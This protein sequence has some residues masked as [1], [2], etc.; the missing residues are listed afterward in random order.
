MRLLCHN[1]YVVMYFCKKLHI[2]V[3]TV[4]VHLQLP[5]S[6]DGFDATELTMSIHGSSRFFARLHMPHGPCCLVALLQ[7]GI[8]H[9]NHEW[10]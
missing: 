9:C 2:K 8:M 1:D 6:S 3:A 7:H 5:C 4:K 10:A